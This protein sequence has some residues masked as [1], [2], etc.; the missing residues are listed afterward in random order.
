MRE[1]ERVDD[2][3]FELFDDIVQSTDIYTIISCNVSGVSFLT[4]YFIG[5]GGGT[6]EYM[7]VCM[8]RWIYNTFKAHRDILRRNNLHGNDLLVFTELEIFFAGSFRS[9]IIIVIIV[10][11]IVLAI[12]P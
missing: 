4:F 9:M 6:G 7:E 10:P 3:F 5:R 1:R 12:F 11:V 8:D 2:G